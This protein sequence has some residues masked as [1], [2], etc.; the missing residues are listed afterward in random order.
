MLCDVA[1]LY[2]MYLI[3][4]TIYLLSHIVSSLQLPCYVLCF[5]DYI[6]ISF[7]IVVNVVT[8]EYTPS[9]SSVNDMVVPQPDTEK[10]SFLSKGVHPHL[11]IS[12]VRAYTCIFTAGCI[13]SFF[14]T[15]DCAIDNKTCCIV[16]KPSPESQQTM[17]GCLPYFTSCHYFIQP[18]NFML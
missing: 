10:V 3:F 16:R 17:V 13:I 15:Q 8:Q 7:T 5:I 4:I 12:T 11:C 6:C 1:N 2:L 14:F 9:K 18:P